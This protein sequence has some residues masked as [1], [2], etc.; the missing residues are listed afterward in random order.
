[1]GK[2]LW[3]GR[4]IIRYDTEK[5]F[6]K[7]RAYWVYHFSSKEHGSPVVRTPHFQSRGPASIPGCAA[8][9]WKIHVYTL[10]YQF[11]LSTIECLKII[12]CVQFNSVAQSCL[13]ATPWTAARQASLSITN[14]WSP[15]KPISIESVMPCSHLI[16][17]HPLLPPSIFPSIRVFSNES[18]LR[19]RWPE[20]W[21]FSF[22]MSLS[23]EHPGLISFRIDWLDLLAVQGTQESSTPQ[24]KNI[25]SL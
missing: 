18:V 13:T 2:W 25:N 9:S 3:V 5:V 23:N 20:Y 12:W 19:I 10:R 7:K 6:N 14:S 15:P 21:S 17:C 22:S 11:T 4:E 24:F 16:L 1:M 8:W